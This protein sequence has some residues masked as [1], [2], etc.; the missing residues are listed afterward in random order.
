MSLLLK[1]KSKSMYLWF[2]CIFPLLLCISKSHAEETSNKEP[3]AQ[4]LITEEETPFAVVDS[5]YEDVEEKPR[6]GIELPF[7]GPTVY[8]ENGLNIDGRYKNVLLSIGGS[9]KIDSGAVDSD[10]QIQ[11]AFPDFSGNNTEFRDAR[12]IMSALIVSAI[13]A[14]LSIDF[15]NIASIKDNWIRF[16]SIKGLDRFRFGYMKVPFSLEEATSS[17]YITFMERA[18]PVQALSPG[19]NFGIRYDR[20][21]PDKRIT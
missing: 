9:F 19:R 5:F 1:I 13:E 6:K 8:W 2:I 15:A 10:E 7:R 14:R 21:I 3:S 17:R 16:T 11:R 20:A 18:L 4:E 12:I